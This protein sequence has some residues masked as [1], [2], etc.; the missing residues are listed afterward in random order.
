LQTLTLKYLFFRQ[1]KNKRRRLMSD[2]KDSVRS[3]RDSSEEMMIDGAHLGAK[4]PHDEHHPADELTGERFGPSVVTTSSESAS[5]FSAPTG[6]KQTPPKRS[7]SALG[8]RV[9]HRII[10]L[11][12]LRA[13]NRFRLIRAIDIAASVFPERELKA[14]L[15]AA[16][17]ATSQ[18]CVAKGARQKKQ[19]V[20]PESEQ[21]VPR[22]LRSQKVRKEPASLVKYRSDAGQTYY[23]L[24]KAGA[25][26][27]RDNG[28]LD[29][30][31]GLAQASVSTVCSKTNPEHEMW[32]NTITLACAARGIQAWNETELKNLLAWRPDTPKVFPLSIKTNRKVHVAVEGCHGDSQLSRVATDII[33][34]LLPDALANT[35]KGAVWIEVDKSVRGGDRRKDLEHVIRHIGRPLSGLNGHL[36]NNRLA[37]V[38]VLCKKGNHFA[39]ITKYLTQKIEDTN[40]HLVHRLET[41]GDDFNGDKPLPMLVPVDGAPGCYG[42]YRY[43]PVKVMSETHWN[44]TLLGYLNIQMLPTWLPKYSYRGTTCTDGWLPD[45]YLPWTLQK[46]GW[47]P[48]TP[49]LPL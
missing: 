19:T 36:T 32:A 43:L 1:Q 25:Q 16:H 22:P 12:V 18:L 10:K 8:P 15:S 4:L 47:G 44:Y 49:V 20:L 23:G 13:A 14:A 29:A 31:D 24:T 3:T 26:W 2:L 27:L 33:K 5:T 28:D 21:T 7:K 9:A 45:N 39:G 48:I 46:G 41:R 42:V 11:L 40:G 34:G 30:G 35:T 6:K 17:R 38:V 37:R